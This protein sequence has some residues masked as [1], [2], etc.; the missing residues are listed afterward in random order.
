MSAP[1]CAASQYFSA[2]TRSAP[3][4]AGAYEYDMAGNPGWTIQA[5]FKPVPEPGATAMMVAGL[6]ALLGLRR[7]R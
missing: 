5:G 6:L 2:T 3:H 1:I 4:D 7:R